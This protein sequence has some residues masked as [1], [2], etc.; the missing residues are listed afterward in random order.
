MVQHSSVTRHIS[1]VLIIPFLTCCLLLITLLQWSKKNLI[2]YFNQKG[3]KSRQNNE[4]LNNIPKSL[5]TLGHTVI[6]LSR[7]PI[8]NASH[9]YKI[10]FCLFHRTF[11]T[12]SISTLFD[13]NSRI[14]FLIKS[15]KKCV[16]ENRRTWYASWFDT[17]LLIIVVVV[18]SRGLSKILKI[19]ILIGTS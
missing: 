6:S 15:T 8:C 18:T 17:I 4:K 11:K 16:V 13:E 2:L 5:L 3:I 19:P 9:P 1:L 12:F 7:H 10:L 14:E